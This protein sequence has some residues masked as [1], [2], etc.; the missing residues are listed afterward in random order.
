[1]IEDWNEKVYEY[2]SDIRSTHVLSDCCCAPLLGEDI[3]S[4]CREHCGTYIEEE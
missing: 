1:M 3:C 4:E 2:I